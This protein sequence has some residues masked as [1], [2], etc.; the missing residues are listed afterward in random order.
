M[1]ITKST[2][3][4]GFT[5][6]ELLVVISIIAILAAISIPTMGLVMNQFRKTQAATQIGNLVNAINLYESKYGTLPIGRSGGEEPLETNQDF[7]DIL[8]GED[9]EQN[10]QETAFFEGKQAKKAKGKR[11]ARAGMIN[12]G[13]GSQSLVDP[14]GN[15]YIVMM[16]A[17]GDKVINVPQEEEPVREDALAWSYGKPED[18]SDHKSARK[19]ELKDWVSSW[20]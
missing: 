5:L 3:P 18:K 7:M 9:R 12:E 19:N 10:P 15:Y 16:D 11:P 1:K 4:S 17:D 20:K 6:I 13:G 2:R 8:T 14:W